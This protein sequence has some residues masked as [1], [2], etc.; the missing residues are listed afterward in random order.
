MI[1]ILIPHLSSPKEDIQ[2]TALQWIIEF[3][4][5]AKDVVLQFTPRIIIAVLPSLEHPVPTIS[6]FAIETNRNLQKLV[7][8]YKAPE[9]V[10][11]KSDPSFPNSNK[12]HNPSSTR[13]EKDTDSMLI[14]TLRRTHRSDIGHQLTKRSEPAPGDMFDYQLT[15]INLRLQLHSDYTLTRIESLRWLM[16]LHTKAREKV[17]INKTCW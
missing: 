10:N 6:A 9:P 12:R 13:Q 11:S 7:M 4:T 3:I 1:E 16:L 15:V 8:E 5:I 17:N 2:R 14:P